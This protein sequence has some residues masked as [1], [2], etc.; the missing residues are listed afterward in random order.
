MERKRNP[1]NFSYLR[2]KKRLA[3]LA[4]SRTVRML[5]PPLA[6]CATF[7]IKNKNRPTHETTH[8]DRH[9][10]A[11]RVD[12]RRPERALP[13]PGPRPRGTRRRPLETIDPRRENR[14]DER[15]LVTAERLDIRAYNWWSEALH[16]V[17]RNG[18]ATV[19]PQSIG[20]AAS[21]D[22]ELVFRAFDAVSDEAR[23]KFHESRRTDTH[24]RYRGLTFGRP[25][26][27]SSATHAGAADERP[28]AK[29]LI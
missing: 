25:T 22:D 10:R 18:L 6:L 20:M 16:G 9:S 3:Y 19:F 24:A 2:I 14:A 7:N 8:A 12:R 4:L 17:G 28:T 15:C 21:F 11:P 1:A 26:S 5:R 29:I 13:Q 23:A 27:T